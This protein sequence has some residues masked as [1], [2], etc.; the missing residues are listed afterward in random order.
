MSVF[1]CE[2]MLKN[3]FLLWKIIPQVVC[4]HIV[5]ILLEQ[6]PKLVCFH[7]VAGVVHFFKY[8]ILILKQLYVKNL[9]IKS[10]I[11]IISSNLKH[12]FKNFTPTFI[13]IELIVGQI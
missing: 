10:D 4:C 11:F 7:K 5:F 13:A 8:C 12:S 3:Y 6:C 1:L 2:Y 9:I